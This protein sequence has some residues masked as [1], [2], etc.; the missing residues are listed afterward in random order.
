MSIL[1]RIPR[2]ELERQFTHY[3]WFL[4]LVP[5][6]IANPDS[7]GPVVSERNWVPEWWFTLAE[8][9]FAMFCLV[10]QWH[11]PAFEPAFPMLISGPIKQRGS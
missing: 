1:H 4:G 8:A 11:D 9:L 3:G 6:Y 7:E 10:S 2:A 5:V